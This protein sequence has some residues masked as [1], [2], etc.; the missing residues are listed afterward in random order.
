MPGLTVLSSR[1]RKELVRDSMV[2]YEAD[3]R[4]ATGPGV[5]MGSRVCH[6][7]RLWKYRL[8]FRASTSTNGDHGT[9]GGL[10]RTG[11][12]GRWWSTSLGGLVQGAEGAVMVD[13]IHDALAF[14]ADLA[15]AIE[16]DCWRAILSR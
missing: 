2:G 3:R 15:S 11:I 8:G 16:V 12:P 5:A 10:P 14:P 9:L 6:D 1:K 7:H 13:D 4:P